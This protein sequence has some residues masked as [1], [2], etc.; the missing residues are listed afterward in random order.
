M[1]AVAYSLFLSISL[2]ACGD[3]LPGASDPDASVDECTTIELGERDFQ[4][5]LFGQLTGVRYKVTPGLD[6]ATADWLYVELYDSTTPDLPPLELGTFPLGTAPNDNLATCQHCV[7][8]SVDWDGESPLERVFVATEGTVTLTEVNDPLDLVFAGTTSE[9]VLREATLDD[10]GASTV[11][12]GGRCL[13]VA[14]VVF[15]TNP[16]PGQ[17]CMSAEDCGNPLLEVCSPATNTCV[18]PEC[19]DYSGCPEDR[20]VCVSQYGTSFLGACYAACDP[21]GPNT[22]PADQQTCTQ[23]SADPTFGYCV[24]VGTGLLNEAC[25]PEDTSTSCVAG[26]TCSPERGVCT[27]T[28]DVYAADPGCQT[29]TVCTVLGRCEPVASG[30]AAEL[31]E[32]CDLE[33]EL[34]QGCAADG[35]A[36]RGICF[37]YG[38]LPMTCEQVCFGD[39]GCEPEEFCALR[40]TTGLGICLPIPVCGDGVLGEINEVCDDGNT[41]SGD[42]CSADCTMVEYGP[43]CDGAATLVDG[44]TTSGDTTTAWD[45]FQASCQLGIARADVY[46]FTPPSRGRLRVALQSPTVQAVSVRSTCDDVDTELGCN[47]TFPF[48]PAPEVI[49]Q[50]TDPSEDL[51]VLVSAYTVLEQGPYTLD[52]EFI[53][54]SCGDGIVAGSEVCD[55]GNTTSGDGCSADCSEIEYDVYCGQAPALTAGTPIPGDT[56]GAPNLYQATCSNEIFGS[57]AERLYTYTAPAAGRLRLT[58]E[59]GDQ[60]LTLAVFDA[61]GAPS[62]MTELACSSVQVEETVEVPVTAGQTVTILVEGFSEDNAGPFTLSAELLPP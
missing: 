11:L 21:S 30:D 54:E 15:D 14:P 7:W 43:I 50:I 38:E 26:L 31:G 34:A 20:P 44:T 33:A 47:T 25:E 3:N 35:G 39:R 42:G 12:D 27:R 6:G 24:A 41:V 32:P 10:T 40:F 46:T 52:T 62:E 48:G 49:V 1:R 60:D 23:P 17:S 51:T 8:M 57:G 36:F 2:V 22:C 58:L 29:G 37:S 16:T 55:D 53:E 19:V 5:N 18:E 4:T 9:L 45:G 28:C 61:C 56:T 59:Q 13:R